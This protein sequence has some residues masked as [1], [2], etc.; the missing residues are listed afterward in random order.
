MPLGPKDRDGIRKKAS[1]QHSVANLPR[2]V[3]KDT[4]AGLAPYISTAD[5]RAPG[6]EIA[7]HL[8]AS[9]ASRADIVAT[10]R[11]DCHAFLRPVEPKD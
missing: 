5:Y 4:G 9:P 10:N 7:L 11:T 2:T 6:R 8:T 3:S 1:C